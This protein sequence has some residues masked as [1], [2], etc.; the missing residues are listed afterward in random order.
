M[1]KNSGI[2]IVY[3]ARFLKSL[4]RLTP[5]IKD[6]PKAREQIFRNN[7]FDPRLKTHKLHGRFTGFRAYSVDYTYRVIFVFDREKRIIYYDIGDHSLYD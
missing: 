3:T 6:A 5:R 2:N 4:K 7:P 1:Q